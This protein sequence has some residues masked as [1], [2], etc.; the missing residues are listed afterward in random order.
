MAIVRR[1]GALVAASI[2]LTLATACGTVTRA[3]DIQLTGVVAQATNV[4]KQPT[5]DDSGV[6]GRIA[7]G[8]TVKLRA[9]NADATWYIVEAP[10]G[11][12][13]WAR[14]ALVQ[15][16]QGVAAHVPVNGTSHCN[17]GAHADN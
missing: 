16:D 15:V 11:Q 12:I 3:S 9:Q 5:M 4:L 13:G 2:L 7:A 10:D 1:V 14:A 6:L 8:T 17:C